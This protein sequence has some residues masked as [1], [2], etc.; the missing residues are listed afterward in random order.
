M[1]AHYPTLSC[2]VLFCMLAEQLQQFKQAVLK[3]A[4]AKEELSVSLVHVVKRVF[5][6]Y[7]S[8]ASS[9]AN[10]NLILLP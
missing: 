9:S 5:A 7:D 4:Q 2:G 1:N 8:C 10:T 6:S 3:H